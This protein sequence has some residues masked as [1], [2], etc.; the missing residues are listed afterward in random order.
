MSVIP[1]NEKVTRLIQYINELSQLKQK[2]IA[3]YKQYDEILWVSQL[4]NEVE[5]KDAFRSESEDWLYVKKPIHPVAPVT[6]V[7]LQDWVTI[8]D[9]KYEFNIHTKIINKVYEHEDIVEKEV[10]LKDFPTIQKQIE[11]FR[12]GLWDPFV[13]EVQRVNAV[14]SLYDQLFTMHQNLQL[15]A[16]S[17]E[18]VV[19]TGF[20]QWNDSSKEFVERH[21][22]TSEVELHFNRERAEFLILPSSKGKMFEYE[23]DMLLVEDRLS[24][25]DMQAIHNLLPELATADSIAPQMTSILQNIAH[26]LD[27]QGTYIPTLD[28]PNVQPDIATVSLSPAF[29]LRKKTQKSFQK[30]CESAIEQ[31]ANMTDDSQIPENLAN[32][33]LSSPL[34][35]QETENGDTIFKEAQEFYFPLPSNEEQNTIISTLSNSSSVLV[36][37]PPGTG[38][39]HT[40]ANLTS[41]LLATGQRVLITSQT[42]KALSVLKSK[43]PTELQNLA[44]SLLGGDSASMKDLEKVVNTISVNKEQFDLSAMSSTVTKNE[45]ILKNLKADLNKTKTELMEIREA[46]TYVHSFNAIYQGTAQQIAEKVNQHFP[47]HNWYTTNV[48]F[49]TPSTFWT[50]EKNLVSEYIRIKN[51]ELEAPVD[52]DQFDYPSIATNVGLNLIPDTIKEENQLKASF[53]LLQT[54]E[55]EELQKSIT[56]L[57][58][59]ERLSFKNELQKLKELQRPLLFNSYP[60]LKN[61]IDDI[62]TNRGF[63]W[64]EIVQKSS[65]HLQ[66]IEDFKGQF[67]DQLINIGGLTTVVAK[68]M[69]EDLHAHVETGGNLGNFLIKPKVVRQYKDQ[70]QEVTYNRLP[71]KSDESVTVLLAYAQTNYAQEQLQQLLVPAL[72]SQ[73]NP[74]FSE[75]QNALAQ[76]SKALHIQ[77]W[78]NNLL[79]KHSFLSIDDFNEKM[80]EALIQNIDILE[81]RNNILSKSTFLEEVIQ[82]LNDLVTEQTH[83]LYQ[84]LTNSIQ[85]RE[86]DAFQE[87][88]IHYNH[89]QEVTKRDHTLNTVFSQLMK[90]SPSLAISLEETYANPV[91]EQRL[92]TWQQAFEWKQTQHWIEQF[93]LKSESTLSNKYDQIENSIKE[94]VVEVGTAKAWIS[95]LQSMT[96]SQNKHLKAWARAV[97]SIGKGTGKNAARYRADAQMHMEK[98]IDSIPA[99][100]MPLNQ[101][102]DNFEIRPNLFDVIIIDEASQSW[103]DAL[104]LKYLAKKL[105]IVGDDKQISPT[106]IGITDEDILKLQNKYFK[107]ID[108]PFGRDL[109][110]KTSFFDISYIMFKDTITLQEHFRCMPEI[111][112]FSNLISYQDQPLIPLRQYPANRLEPIKSVYLPHA[113]REGSSQNAY[114][115]VEADTIVQEI[116]NCIVDPRYDGKTIGVISLLGENQAKLIQ[117][118]LLNTLGAEVM[119]DRNIICGD[120]YA[121]QGDERD[122]IFLSMVVANGATRITATTD[123][124][125][126]QRFNVAASRAKDQLW[127]MHSITVNDISNHDCLRY[128]LL[129]YV[130]NPIKEET[131]S[132]REKCESNFEKNV[133]DDITSR[134][135]RVIPQYN[136]ANY[137]IDLVIQGEKSKLAVECDGDH[138][139][140]SV[141][142]RERDFLRERV[143]QRAGWT[144]SRVLGSSYYHNPEKA[145]ESLWEKI[146]EMGIRPYAEWHEEPSEIAIG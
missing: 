140:T 15:Y 84:E 110:L 125:A 115:E 40:I 43:L 112:G 39:T 131:E 36:Q 104:L 78:R 142:D 3:S 45:V 61:V 79:H 129:S 146:D 86:T 5:C 49:D 4:P 63:V 19:S 55:L 60:A 81:L 101:V 41:H 53:K 54:L 97:K 113:I 85:A 27:S 18:L 11:Q 64:E 22:L 58:E 38:K 89:F 114:N 31:L 102:Y 2:P 93:S 90:E 25:E 23:E 119:E 73:A 94:S 69:A 28:I 30:A 57:S 26:A 108:F 8:D 46:E 42:A 99:W 82:K 109:N 138:W 120:A 65:L 34:S 62:F 95:M 33:F 71:I 17:L 76:L 83:P 44:V 50:N 67:D 16:E 123:D 80:V 98:C 132:N 21:L 137:R 72:L 144:F 7:T 122:I 70:L 6:P 87:N 66:T 111:I 48:T 12:E 14:Q 134:G 127:L 124:K 103:H 116:I 24:G 68:K 121:F 37:G 141:E 35:D 133:F 77:E 10:F 92:T 135:Y 91:W 13:A 107:D 20:L 47:A 145:L 1:L 29:I 117:N 128:Q 143:L 88:L 52:Y 100:I 56:N 130:A 118:K 105:I 51:I 139:H 136:A 96:D 126:R 9:Q 59:E 74:T 75:V 106:I 32:M